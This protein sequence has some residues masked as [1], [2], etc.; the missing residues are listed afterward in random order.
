M[1][2]QTPKTGEA[3]PNQGP[4]PLGRRAKCPQCG[5]RSIAAI[6]FGMPSWSAELEAE[7]ASGRLVLGG[8]C[9]TGDDPDRHCNGCGHDWRSAGRK[10]CC[11]QGRRG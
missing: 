5:S 10:G 9:V 3:K 6:G 1:T 11:G 2:G 7:L 8:C 4:T